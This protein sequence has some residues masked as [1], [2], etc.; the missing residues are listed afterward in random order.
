MKSRSICLPL[1]WLASF[2][3]C[4]PTAVFANPDT[5]PPAPTWKAAEMQAFL[6]GVINTYMEENKLAGATL[7][8][9]HRNETLLSM[10]YGYA[11][12]DAGLKVDAQDHLFR[13]GSIS[14]LFVWLAVMQQVE[15]G[16]LCLDTDVNDYLES[17]QIPDT[18]EVPV[19]LRS[20]MTHT[21]GFEDILLHL[22]LREDD[23]VGSTEEIL[24]AQ[25]PKRVRPPLQIASYSN[26]GTA[27]AQYLVE[28]SSGQPFEDYVEQHILHPLQMSS[29]TFRQPL[30]RDLAGQLSKAYAWQEGRFVEKAFELIPISGMGGASTTAADMAIFMKSLLNHSCLDTLCLL[31]SLTFATMTEPVMYHA[32]HTNPLMLGFMDVSQGGQRLYGHGG[33]TFLFHS[34]MVLMPEHDLGL[35]V[36]F[37]SEAGAM[38]PQVL[39][40]QFVER[41][42]PDERPLA[43]TIELDEDYLKGFEG[44][45]KVNRHSHSDFFKLLALSMTASIKLEDGMLRMDDPMGE[46]TWWL[47]IDSVSFRQADSNETIAFHRPS[48]EKAE[49]LFLGNLSILAFERITGLWHPLLH[50]IIAGLSLFCI[51]Y[52][53]LV[54]PWFYFVRR[55]YDRGSRAP[56]PIPVGAK[57]SAWIPSLFFLVFIILT[58]QA[59]SI[60]Q[61]MVFGVPASLRRALFFPLAA[62]PFI[63]LMIYQMV[64][65]WGNDDIRF[66]S[67]L[68]YTLATFAFVAFIWQL[69]FW[70]LLGWRY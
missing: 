37:N 48:G 68:F 69:H 16:H 27:L 43:E 53:L 7:S 35:F 42:F 70:N 31:D 21:P 10:G 34:V 13:I 9:V 14:K 63:L 55:Q 65:L 52:I 22:F 46:T 1:L 23:E 6:D 39:V 30:P 41:F 61:E 8:V 47:P 2:W 5:P 67:R 25:L 45:Y 44:V 26:H 56:S 36:S 17:F 11:D 40:K 18:Y 49:I 19:T 20:L 38:G 15:Q 62:I 57:I 51:I 64:R 33:N 32:P 29:T 66:F 4:L 54:W 58:I 28:L 59:T 50:G 60:G 3:L 24:K 12:V